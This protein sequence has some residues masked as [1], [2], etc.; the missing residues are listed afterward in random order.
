MVY[1]F[2]FFEKMKLVSSRSLNDII[3]ISILKLGQ[4]LHLKYTK[5]C[6]KSELKKL[7]VK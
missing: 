6:I 5:K 1:F 7:T 4:Q 2:F 3:N